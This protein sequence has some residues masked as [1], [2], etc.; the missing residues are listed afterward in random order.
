MNKDEEI[1]RRIKKDLKYQERS[2]KIKNQ[3]NEE[4]EE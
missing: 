2:R 4:D 3:K 1:S